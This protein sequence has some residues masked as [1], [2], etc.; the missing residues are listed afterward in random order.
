MHS[1][2][3]VIFPLNIRLPLFQAL[4]SKNMSKLLVGNTRETRGALSVNIIYK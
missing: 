2:G 1:Q 4:R 3:R